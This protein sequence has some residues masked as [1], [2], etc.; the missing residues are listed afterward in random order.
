M[1]DFDNITKQQ[2]EFHVVDSIKP[3]SHNVLDNL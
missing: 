2:N 3:S 1:I